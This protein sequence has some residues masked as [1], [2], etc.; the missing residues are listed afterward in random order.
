MSKKTEYRHN[1][2]VPEWYQ[3]RFM[4]PNRGKYYYMDLNPELKFS[5]GRKFT[6][7]SV[8]EWGPKSCFAQDNLYTYAEQGIENIDIERFFFGEIDREGLPAV[9]MFANFTNSDVDKKLLENMVR[10]MS[11]QKLRTP[12]GLGWVSSISKNK[13]RYL[14]LVLMQKIQYMFCTTWVECIWQIAD[15]SKS[16]VG[17]IIS[18]NPVTVYNRECFP[19][20]RDCRNF[21][22]PDIRMNATHTYFPLSLNK[23]LIL[24]NLSWARNPYQNGK[25]LRPNPGLYRPTMFSFADIQ[26]GRSLNTEEVIQINYI[27][28]TRAH[29][30]LASPEKDWL[31]PEGY[32]SSTLWNSF[33]GGYLFMP[34]PRDLYMGGEVYIGYE[35]GRSDAYSAYGHRPW[36]PG[37]RDAERDKRDARALDR[38]KAEFARLNGP[39]WRGMSARFNQKAPHVDSA[40]HHAWLLSE[41]REYRAKKRRNRNR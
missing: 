27:T 8:L 36:Q 25:K 15:T 34:E 9:N 29:K 28:K 10:Y 24:T 6:R 38:F 2:Y 12:K 26:T 11:V 14:D 21:N 33:G 31:Y 40:E 4:P 5:N 18:D 7:R 3:R 17:F 1:H 19:G 22:D 32:L 37:F 35:G 16:S 13:N 30:Y 41:D 20:S 23:I 39:T